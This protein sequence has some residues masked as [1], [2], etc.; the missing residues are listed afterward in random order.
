METIGEIV[1]SKL[2]SRGFCKTGSN[3]FLSS[4]FK[5]TS[6]SGHTSVQCLSVMP[7]S[8]A[9]QPWRRTAACIGTLLARQG[10][11]TLSR[12]KPH[13]GNQV[14]GTGTT[15]QTGRLPGTTTMPTCGDPLSL[16][17]EDATSELPVIP[18]LS[19]NPCDPRCLTPPQQNKSLFCQYLDM[20]STIAVF[21]YFDHFTS[22]VW[23]ALKKRF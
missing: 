2:K 21:V 15:R 16:L 11:L 4:T 9:Q 6:T 13:Q 8:Q 10:K 3:V 23:G 17:R 12:G 20:F 1:S 5:P 7:A 19:C 22:Q 18:C 14:P